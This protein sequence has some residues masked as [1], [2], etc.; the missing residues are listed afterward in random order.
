MSVLDAGCGAG[1]YLRSLRQRIDP[2]IDYHGID[3]SL[4]YVT[5]ARSAF[6]DVKH[7]DVAQITE[8][9]F[10]DASIDIVICSNVLPNLAAPP[11]AALAELV[12]VARHTVLLRTLFAD[13]NYLIQEVDSAHS[14]NVDA[15]GAD[16]Q[17]AP[18]VATHNNI[19]SEQ[20][21]CNVLK[22][23]QP[24]LIPIIEP[25]THAQNF[26]SDD[27]A[28]TRTFENRQIAGPLLLDW[29]FITILI[30]RREI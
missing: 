13:V 14:D 30:D 11:H 12:R 25:D 15:I 6:P 16:G 10:A 1:H 7:F 8:L 9:P 24:D 29:R 28:G 21:L 19:Y 22:S 3:S 18:G 20:Y 17:P 4:H 5:L 27:P 26:R 23:I 2:D